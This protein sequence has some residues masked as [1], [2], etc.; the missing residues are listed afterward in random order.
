MPP[1]DGR[2]RSTLNLSNIGKVSKTAEEVPVV[3]ER[4][5]DRPIDNDILKKA[6]EDFIELRKAI[7]PDLSMLKRGYT[8]E[9]NIINLTLSGTVE[10][11][12][13]NTL[14]TSLITFLR[15]RT[16]NSSLI[17]EGKIIEQ[18]NN[19]ERKL[20]TTKE[21]FDHLAEKNP[22]LKEMKDRLGLDPD[23]A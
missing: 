17:V 21:K 14:K 1:K 5:P 6:W 11:M 18:V 8:L 15:D 19:G 3:K 16:G 9:G 4:T 20:F 13:F 23:F 22:V 10:E 7:T 2:Q 12:L